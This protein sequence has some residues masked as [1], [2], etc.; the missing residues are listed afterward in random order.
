MDLRDRAER[1]A[2]DRERGAS[3]LVAELL[4]I[5]DAAI[6][7]GRQTTVDV[8]RAVCLGQSAMAPI[9]KICAAALADFADPGRYALRRA[10]F[11][12]APRALARAASAALRDALADRDDRSRQLLTLSSSGSVAAAL[13]AL[14]GMGIQIDVVCGESLPGGEGASMAQR[15]HADGIRVELVCDALLTTYLRSASAVLVGADAVETDVWTNKAG[16]YGLAAAAWF[17]GVPVYVICSRDKAA[18]PALGA[19]LTSSEL[20]ERTPTSLATL[21]LTE[22]GPVSPDALGDL[23]ARHA[24]D[25]PHLLEIL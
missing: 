19:R 3:A 23:V 12:R 2:A 13:S 17:S 25:L 5:L 11:A 1:I 20:F 10:E 9:W 16:T 22:V 18:P 4:P 24:D 21:F 14:P 7:D 6:A 15:L 8:A